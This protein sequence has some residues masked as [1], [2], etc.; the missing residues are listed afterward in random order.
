MAGTF[1]NLL[2]H[3]VFSTKYRRPQIVAG[4]RE[5]LYSYIGGIIRADDAT[6]VE[7]GGIADHVHLVTRFR[8]QRSVA[9]M[10]KTFKAKSSKWVNE[11]RRGDDRFYWQ[12]GYAAFT[13]SPSQLSNVIRYVRNQQEH[14]RRVTFQEEYISLLQRHGVEYDERYLWD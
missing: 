13:V 9:E 11:R 4:L 8:T 10:V 12:T 5:D 3:I 2:Y 6:L 7:I 1:T 14:H